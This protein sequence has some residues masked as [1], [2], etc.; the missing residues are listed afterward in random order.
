M[1]TEYYAAHL[2]SPRD[3]DVRPCQRRLALL[4]LQSVHE[5]LEEQRGGAAARGLAAG[6]EKMQHVYWS[7]GGSGR[8]ATDVLE[9]RVAGV[10][11]RAVVLVER[12][13]PEAV[14]LRLARGVELLPEGVG[15]L[16][17]VS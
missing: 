1:W 12:H 15:C 2:H 16:R 10:D 3:V 7:I 17:S 6:L 9:V 8:R 5:R 11:L 4:R 14:V 13:A